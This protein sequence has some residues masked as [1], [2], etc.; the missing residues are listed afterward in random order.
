M[1]QPIRY[2][3]DRPLCFPLE[4][5]L[6]GS[7]FHRRIKHALQGTH[8]IIRPNAKS[9]CQAQAEGVGLLAFRP[10]HRPLRCHP[11]LPVHLTQAVRDLFKALALTFQGTPPVPRLAPESLPD[12]NV[13]HELQAAVV[14]MCLPLNPV[15]L[16]RREESAQSNREALLLDHLARRSLIRSKVG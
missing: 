12:L 11:L 13:E 3:L 7:D 14:A 8:T 10:G 9:E 2:L 1:L 4:R 15:R 5:K 16:Q 6:A